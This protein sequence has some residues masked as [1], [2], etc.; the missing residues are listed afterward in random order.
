MA[1]FSPMTPFVLWSYRL[2]S[3][4]T[5]RLDDPLLLFVRAGQS[6]ATDAWPTH[7]A[8][9]RP[10]ANESKPIMSQRWLKK[11][12]EEPGSNEHIGEMSTDGNAVL[13][14]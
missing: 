5:T 14:E 3:S 8:H 7:A 10:E 6:R 13:V 11:N 1:V 9:Q 12:Q 4:P 2:A